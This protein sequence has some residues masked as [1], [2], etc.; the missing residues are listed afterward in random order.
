MRLR[1]R[2][3]ALLA[4]L[5]VIISFIVGGTF[6]Y[7]FNHTIG[8]L[9]KV[10]TETLRDAL[11]D[12][13]VRQN[14]QKLE[15][16]A[17]ALSGA[18]V[19]DDLRTL[20][21]IIRPLATLETVSRIRVYDERDQLLVDVSRAPAAPQQTRVLE[22]WQTPPERAN[23]LA[24]QPEPL[25]EPPAREATFTLT[26]FAM[27]DN[28]LAGRLVVSYRI[29]WVEEKAKDLSQALQA[30]YDDWHA[31]IIGQEIL[32]SL[33][34]VLLAALIG[35][36][37][38]QRLADPVEKINDAMG[39]LQDCNYDFEIDYKGSDELNDLARAVERTAQRLKET[40]VSRSHFSSILETMR[41]ALVIVDKEGLVHQ[42]NQ[43]AEQEFA[44][45]GQTLRQSNI[46]AR[47]AEMPAGQDKLPKS[48]RVKMWRGDG[49][50]GHYLYSGSHLP[51]SRDLPDLFVYVLHDIA[52][53]VEREESLLEA[54]RLAEQSNRSKTAFI[55]NVSH[56]LRTPLN[57]I[58]GFSDLMID[59]VNG[60]IG[61]EAYA[62][63]IRHTKESGERLLTLIN[64]ILDLTMLEAD[65]L[66]LTVEPL[67]IG[68]IAEIVEGRLQS[69]DPDRTLTTSVE[70]D[71]ANEHLVIH[72][73]LR[74][75][76]QVLAQI[77]DNAVK[78]TPAGGAV[79]VSLT[80][81]NEQL[82]ILV[83]D[84]GRGM[85]D[86]ALARVLE[87]FQQVEETSTRSHEG[88]G[89]G[90]THAR[91]LVE[92]HGGSLDLE[93]S[94]G[95]GTTVSIDLPLKAQGRET[96]DPATASQADRAA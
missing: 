34:L 35:A 79:A 89:L 84:S 80:I 45:P 30:T 60:P 8:D 47:V 94:L 88:A 29:G 86:A 3:M 63:Y 70:I 82:Q 42:A 68:A 50:V 36:H 41:D 18:L 12:R 69:L 22:D 90:L 96:V 64:Q 55:N 91:A 24:P 78:F 81:Q 7:S 33:L 53:I 43:Q 17:T 85:D 54:R 65:A 93:S 92:R 37:V 74:R 71:E 62:D 48:G 10:G 49:R 5:S 19:R 25:P 58:I 57:A 4:S 2:Y 21:E 67:E 51:P 66:R 32:T 38:A 95:E 56:E 28:Q 52:D 11:L 20:E 46:F 61:N 39:D 75:L 26:S 77:L 9:E 87:P 16:I 14:Q 31:D 40:T 27:A 15:V 13:K 76:T 1:G 59:G 44:A 6:L 23:P 72:C 73:D 83:K